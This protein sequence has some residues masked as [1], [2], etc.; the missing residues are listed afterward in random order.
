MRGRGEGLEK[1]VMRGGEKGCQ[2]GNTGYERGMR[3]RFAEDD[4]AGFVY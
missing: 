3:Q 1:G 2:G 4:D